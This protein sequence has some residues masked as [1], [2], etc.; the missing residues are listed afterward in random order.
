MPYK[1]KGR[2]VY[3]RGKKVGSS[4]S[5]AKARKYLRTLQAVE[6]GWEPGQR[7]RSRKRKRKS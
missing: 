4:K 1:L 2:T 3:K 5:A 7:K 6:H